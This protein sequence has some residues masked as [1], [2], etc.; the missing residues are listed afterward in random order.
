MIQRMGESGA[1]CNQEVDIR[2]KEVQG[3]ISQKLIKPYIIWD[4][5][6]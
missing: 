1:I 4:K 6:S 2:W 5:F 3:I